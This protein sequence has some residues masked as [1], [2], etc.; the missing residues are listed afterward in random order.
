MMGT[1]HSRR[2]F[3]RKPLN[4]FDNSGEGSLEILVHTVCNFKGWSS[5]RIWEDQYL[6]VVIEIVINLANRATTEDP[7]H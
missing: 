7:C 2:I 4:T 3:W 6:V 1:L 5:Y